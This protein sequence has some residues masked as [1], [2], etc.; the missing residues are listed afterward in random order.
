MQKHIELSKLATMTEVEFAEWL[1]LFTK[2]VD[3]L[4]EGERA[5]EAKTRAATI[6]QIMLHKIQTV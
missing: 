2:T 6:A 3:V 4:F 5:T 1:K